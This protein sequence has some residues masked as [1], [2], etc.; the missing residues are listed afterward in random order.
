MRL[1]LLQGWL[2]RA[3]YVLRRLL[4]FLACTFAPDVAAL[5]GFPVYLGWL[6]RV[7]AYYQMFLWAATMLLWTGV[8][9]MQGR[10]YITTL[11]TATLG[12]LALFEIQYRDKD[13]PARQ[14]AVQ[15]LQAEAAAAAALG[16]HLPQ[17]TLFKSLR[18]ALLTWA[19]SCTATLQ[20]D[21]RRWDDMEWLVFDWQNNRLRALSHM[22][23]GAIGRLTAVFF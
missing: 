18:G 21:S 13:L 20:R 10:T 22:A 9:T 6:R 17:A 11:G 15:A 16:N 12:A 7:L 2:R 14:K 1:P 4:C 23:K 5:L 19:G 8:V 3:L